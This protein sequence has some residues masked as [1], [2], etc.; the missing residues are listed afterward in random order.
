ME[1]AGEPITAV[2]TRNVLPGRER[3][4][5]SGRAAWS[6]QPLPT[7]QPDT[8]SSLLMPVSRHVEF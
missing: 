4:Y 6:P 3:D 7:V 5:E 8:R 1:Q 2:V